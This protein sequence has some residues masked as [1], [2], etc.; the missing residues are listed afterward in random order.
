MGTSTRSIHLQKVTDRNR[1]RWHAFRPRQA[2][3]D[4]GFNRGVTPVTPT[5]LRRHGREVRP[6]AT[7]AAGNGG[8]GR[9]REWKSMRQKRWV[10]ASPLDWGASGLALE[11][12][13]SVAARWKPS[14]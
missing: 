2:T 7:R 8:Q 1:P 9:N 4:R 12:V 6:L 14:V 3:S 13:S 5:G 11:S 10:Q